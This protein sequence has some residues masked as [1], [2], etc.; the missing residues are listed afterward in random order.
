MNT[1]E[2]HIL[3]KKFIFIFMVSVILSVGIIGL[4]LNSAT[5]IIN[6]TSIHRTL[7]GLIK[8]QDDIESVISGTED[9]FSNNAGLIKAFSEFMTRSRHFCLV[10]KSPD[11][12][13]SAAVYY[14]Y[15]G[16]SIGSGDE[17][18]SVSSRYIEYAEKAIESGNKYGRYGMNYYEYSGSGDGSAVVAFIDCTS[19][20][21]SGSRLLT[22]TLIIGLVALLISYLIVRRLS[23]RI[24][25]PVIENNRRQK[26]F[27]TN[28]SHEL[29]TPLAVIRANTELTEIMNGPSEWTASTLNQVD[30]MNGLI[31]NL[32]MITKSAE[33]EDKSELSEIDAGKAVNESVTPYESLAAQ[34]GITLERNIEENVTITAD[35]SKIRQL[36]TLLV[37][38]AIKYCDENGRIIVGLKATGKRKKGICLT[39]SNSYAAGKDVDYNLFF[40]RFYR[41][42]SSHNIDKGGYGI[43]LSIADSICSRYG[44]E[45][46]ASWEDG[47]ITFT[48]LLY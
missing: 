30:R 44:G 16:D 41:E 14:G 26:E 8:Y 28:A 43:G 9:P 46:K 17:N 40:D 37:D 36:T 12:T 33:Q 27:I 20:I 21:N 47:M 5:R 39:V 35:A 34:K 48:C 6:V 31:Q 38:N 32:V 3:R 23:L 7:D 24:I 22:I 4:A 15:T 13:F 2:I 42:D 25:R 18:T 29:K 11:G 10:S 1:R 45:I 19:E